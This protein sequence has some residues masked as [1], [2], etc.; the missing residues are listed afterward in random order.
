MLALALGVVVLL[1]RGCDPGYAYFPHDMSGRRID[2]WSGTI[3]GV[4]FEM[5]RLNALVDATV[6]EGLDITN[7]SESD[8]VVVSA[9]VETN[10][11]KSIEAE[12]PRTPDE[13]REYWTVATGKSHQAIASWNFSPHKGA[14]EVL[15]QRI[16][17]VW[18][19]RIGTK[20]HVLRVRMEKE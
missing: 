20:E 9:L 6:L 18:K 5:K 19:V 14:D 10:D 16:T 11:G 17:W 2:H 1:V 15:G 8:V 3:D 13:K 12:W 7:N 4:E